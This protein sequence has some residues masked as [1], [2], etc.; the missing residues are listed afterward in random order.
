MILFSD[1]IPQWKVNFHTH[2]TRSD[3]NVTPEEAI[4]LY[5]ERGYDALCITDHRKCYDTLS[6]S[7]LVLNGIELD[8]TYPHE[9]I[10]LV[11]VGLERSFS[12]D[13]LQH[14]LVSPHEGIRIAHACG[15]CVIFAHPAWSLNT[16]ETLM[17]YPEADAVEVFNSISEPPYNAQRGDASA[18]LD[19]AFSRGCRFPLCANDDA[20]FY[21]HDL[22]KSWTMVAASDCTRQALM[23]AMRGGQIYASQGPVFRE[24]A[25]EGDTL[26][27]RTSPVAQVM[28]FSDKCWVSG[29]TREGTD[30]MESAYTMNGES[31]VRVR[32]TDI[33]GC[34]AWSSPIF[35][36]FV[37][38]G[39]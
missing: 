3:G 21:V 10:H 8:Y 11:A 2:T 4:R 13:E 1:T 36:Q 19:G 6:G 18:I 33:R 26:R 38:C 25:L 34:H 20:H 14:A 12:P 28:F 35:G 30:I 24:I 27:I 23:K 9:V 16:A 7:P 32:I 22:A 29:R 37:S 15:G 39:E 17:A 31:F 5:G